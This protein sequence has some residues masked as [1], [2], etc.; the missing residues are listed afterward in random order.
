M[1]RKLVAI[2]TIIGA[3]A[4]A[5]PAAATQT[6]LGRTDNPPAPSCPGPPCLAVSRTTGFQAK[7]GDIRS[8]M[9]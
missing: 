7:I 5:A 8:P 1:Q 9:I 4:A 3:F 2:A 6:D